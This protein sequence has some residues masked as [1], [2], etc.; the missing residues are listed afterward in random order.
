MSHANVWIL[1]NSL[2]MVFTSWISAWLYHIQK[3]VHYRQIRI[4]TVKATQDVAAL[5][6]KCDI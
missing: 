6:L 3:Q 4:L 1:P 2:E 5:K